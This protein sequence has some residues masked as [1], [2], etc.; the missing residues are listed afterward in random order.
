MPNVD[1]KAIKDA[2]LWFADEKVYLKPIATDKDLNNLIINLS[3]YS[4][5]STIIYTKITYCFSDYET[6]ID[7]TES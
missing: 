7:L 5:H 1:N 3:I 6:L 2:N 4:K